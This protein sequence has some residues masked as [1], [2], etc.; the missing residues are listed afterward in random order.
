MSPGGGAPAARP[1]AEAAADVPRPPAKRPLVVVLPFDEIGADPDQH[2]FAAGLTADLAIDLTRCHSLRVASPP[3]AG[4]WRPGQ[5]LPD[6]PGLGE[7][8]APRVGYL[9]T[10]SVRRAGSRIRVTA[11]LEEAET[12][13]HLWADRFDRQMDDLF[14]VQEELAECLASRLATQV[15]QEGMRRARSRPPA[16]LDAYDLCLRGRDLRRRGNQADTLRA[17]GMFDLSI[18]EDPLYAPSHAWLSYTL[19]RGFSHRW[20]EPS[21]R[22]ALEPSLAAARRAV[23]LDPESPTC[24]SRLGFMQALS[25]RWDEGLE[26]ARAAVALGPGVFEARQAYAQVLTHAGDAEEAVRQYALA[27]SL[28]PFHP[29]GARVEYARALLLADRPEEAFAELRACAVREP[30]YSFCFQYLA[31]A[32]MELGLV[33]EAREAVRQLLRIGPYWTV[34]NSDYL[35]C[36]RRPA[37]GERFGSALRAAGLPEG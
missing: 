36:F 35:Y 33:G 30:G 2:Y 20:G 21:G 1:F 16:S 34:R 13:V 32:A 19:I 17:R 3:R 23:E 31:T 18:A 10:G 25:G 15:D 12:G 24:V 5:A 29:V 9:V 22:D 11:R 28:D 14:A 37:D 27:L 26:T 4:V 8:A 7:A 6:T